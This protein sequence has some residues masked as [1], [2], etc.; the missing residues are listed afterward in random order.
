M[1][2]DGYLYPC[3]R[4]M[5]SSLGDKRPPLRIG[6]VDE[7]VAQTECTKQCIDCLNSI[8][9]RSQSTDECYDCPIS[10]GCAWC[11][12]YNYEIFGTPN[13]RVTFNCCMHKARSLANVYFWNTYYIK[14]DIDKIFTMHCPKEWAL[15]IISEQEYNMLK[16]L[17]ER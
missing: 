8:T 12:A 1:D 5:E 3:I 9:R 7:G 10:A 16:S 4:Y 15:E 14:H 11:S 6:H 13:K 17:E 2:P